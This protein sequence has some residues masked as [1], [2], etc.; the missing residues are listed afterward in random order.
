MPD[1]TRI[2]RRRLAFLTAGAVA[3]TSLATP[4]AAHAARP[5]A[6]APTTTTLTVSAH[7]TR[8]DTPVQLTAHVTASAG[9]P[10]GTV[11]FVDANGSDLAAATL[12]QG[13]AT[14]STAALAP[15]QRDLTAVY[16]GTTAYAASRS[17]A[18]A[19]SV[20]NIGDATAVQ[21][22][23]AHDGDQAADA[24]NPKSLTRRW[25]TTFSGLDGAALSG[26]LV[27]DGLVFTS[28][29]TSVGQTSVYAVSQATGR[30]AW[31]T[32]V[33][34]EYNLAGLAYDGR[35]LFALAYGGRL[36]A[37]A[38]ATGYTLWSVQ[39]PGEYAFDASP[40]AY[41]GV[42]Y[43]TG[44]GSDAKIYAVRESDGT[45]LWKHHADGEGT[46]AVSGDAAY[47]SLACPSAYRLS[48]TGRVVWQQ[49][50]C[51]GGGDGLAALTGGH[52]Y[53]ENTSDVLPAVILAAGTGALQS[54]FLTSS[55]LA[56][57]AV[58]MYALVGGNLVAFDP[59]GYPQR[60]AFGSLGGGRLDVP[61]VADHGDVFAGSTNGKIYAL[62][63]AGQLA[64]S[65]T[66]NPDAAVTSL[67]VGDG[68]LA[69]TA[70]N[71]LTAF[72]G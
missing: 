67:T 7:S 29:T 72:S 55:A 41:D 25:R 19:V 50:S 33:A 47:L 65:G 68:L 45:L 4:A 62:T 9:T 10:A 15:G 60:W 70:S 36:T 37:L 17:A 1:L 22:D 34:S 30:I 24:L 14:V 20:T 59:Q 71:V 18:A 38:A 11:T 27:A 63:P 26:P 5:P 6:A 12:T 28:A 66:A 35:T 61:P 21:I 13:T 44:A 2:P 58:N 48:L 42:V 52:L 46:P 56:F 3:V 40:T 57:D 51:Q 69:A 64:W 53:A 54:Q 16:A 31:T 43:L 23:P 49:V 39:L 32:L 8:Y